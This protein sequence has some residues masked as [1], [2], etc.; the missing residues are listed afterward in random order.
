MDQAVLD[1]NTKADAKL[2]IVDCDIHPAFGSPAELAKFLPV[3][4]RDHLADY[5]QRSA[6]PVVGTL[7]YPRMT[8][9]NG[10]RRDSW[11]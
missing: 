11:P 2:G 1:K 4:W 5:G 9:G 6:N 8:P 3:R 10:M 7:P